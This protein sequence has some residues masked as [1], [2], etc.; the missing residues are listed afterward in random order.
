MVTTAERLRAALSTA[1]FPAS[2]EDL[3][4]C[5]ERAEADSGTIGA[6]NAIPPVQYDNLAEVMQS[7]P[8]DQGH[9][10]GEVAQRR[11]EHDKPGLAQ[12][13]KDVTGHPIVDELGENRGS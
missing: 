5:A 4:R 12:Q 2:K 7:A 6:L 1:D 10:P 3:V 13:E 9:E 8:F 11:Q